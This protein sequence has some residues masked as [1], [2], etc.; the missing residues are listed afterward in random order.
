MRNVFL[1]LSLVL[2]LCGCCDDCEEITSDSLIKESLLA[3]D[4]VTIETD[5]TIL[6]NGIVIGKKSAALTTGCFGIPECVAMNE[7]NRGIIK[8][9]TDDFSNY[10]NFATGTTYFLTTFYCPYWA[11]VSNPTAMNALI[12]AAGY[13]DKKNAYCLLFPAKCA[14]E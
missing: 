9:S 2:A 11:H 10:D 6:I 14:E 5:D 8:K 13:G 4:I 1:A 7:V 3:G 12:M